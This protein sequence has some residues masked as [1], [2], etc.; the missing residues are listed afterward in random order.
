MKTSMLLSLAVPALLALAA[1]AHAAGANRHA[2]GE[3][4]VY[5]FNEGDRDGREEIITLTDRAEALKAA[6]GA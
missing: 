2:L 5:C 1:S 3:Y 4:A 6:V